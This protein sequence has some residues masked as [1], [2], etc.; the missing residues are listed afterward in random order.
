MLD[1]LNPEERAA[2]ERLRT[3][4]FPTYTAEAVVH[5][6]LRDALVGCGVL[7][8]PASNRSKGARKTPGRGPRGSVASA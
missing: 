6:L 4:L 7:N 8:L 3:E 1:R 2:V 5:K